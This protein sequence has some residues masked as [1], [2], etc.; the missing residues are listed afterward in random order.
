MLRRSPAGTPPARTSAEAA[1]RLT[2]VGRRLRHDVGDRLAAERAGA[3]ARHV[4]RVRPAQLVVAGLSAAE[5]ERRR[6]V[7]GPNEIPRPPAA[8]H[9]TPVRASV[10]RPVRG[11]ASGRVGDHR[12]RAPSAETARGGTLQ[13][14]LAILFGVVLNAVTAFVLVSPATCSTNVRAGQA[15]TWQKNR[16]TRSRISTGSRPPRRLPGAG[17][18]L[19]PAED[20]GQAD[21]RGDIAAMDADGLRYLGE[22]PE[23]GR[24]P[25][26]F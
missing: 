21:A 10:H 23:P 9:L 14:A 3:G 26:Y 12:P 16:G 15:S 2:S 8:R 20:R 19:L 11:G 17:T 18:P 22:A 5:V 25:A 4:G 1:A 6:E 7:A 13:L 24:C